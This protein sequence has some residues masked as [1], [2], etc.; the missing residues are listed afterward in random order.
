MLKILGGFVLVAIAVSSAFSVSAAENKE[1]I[2]GRNIFRSNCIS[3]H[4]KTGKGSPM[5]AK[6]FKVDVKNMD[7]ASAH[8]AAMK[9]Q[10]IVEI[11]TNGKAGK[12]PTFK[13]KLGKKEITEVAS[14]IRSLGADKLRKSA[15]ASDSAVKKSKTRV[16]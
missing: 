3:C 7:L 11:I 2:A 16:R 15:K 13:G 8:V 6:M 10:E 12:M 5:M 14:Y 1:L 4:L 9:K